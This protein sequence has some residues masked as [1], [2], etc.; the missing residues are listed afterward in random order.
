VSRSTIETGEAAALALDAEDDPAERRS[1]F[2]IP[3]VDGRAVAYFAGNSLG[4]QPIGARIAVTEVLDAWATHGVDG[5]LSGAH[6]WMPYHEELRD[7]VARVVGARPREAVVMNSLTVNLHLLLSSFYRPT[8]GRFRIVIEHDAFPSDRYAVNSRAALHGLDPA[9]AVVALHPAPGDDVITPDTVRACL[10]DLGDT[11]AVVLLGTINY[12]TGALLDVP[13]ITEVIHAAGAVAGWDCAHAAGNVPL[14]L[15]DWNVDFAVWCSYKYLNSGP[16]SLGGAFVHERHA[17]DPA[18]VRPAGWWGHDPA[19]RFHMPDA[20]VAQPGA[21]SWQLSNPPI[22]SMAAV[23][24][25]LELFDTVGMD[26]IRARSLRLTGYLEMLIDDVA[27]RRSV[28]LLTPRN[29]QRRGAQLSIEVDDAEQV[30]AQLA[31]RFGVVADERPPNIVRL[32]PAPLYTSFHD[33][34]RAAHAL[35]EV[36]A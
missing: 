9:D 12:R 14:Q 21:E 18:V 32:A 10:H 36:L 22:L 30:T 29:V 33:C 16:G 17:E 6:P 5:H 15:H 7:T 28:R 3:H 24:A 11:V 20:F 34:W 8:A 2:A 1:E 13:V 35:E 31:R 4:L 26:A 19:P 27:E 23:R 25:S